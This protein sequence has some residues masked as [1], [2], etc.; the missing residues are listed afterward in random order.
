MFSTSCS[1]VTGDTTTPKVY[2]NTAIEISETA[3]TL[4]FLVQTPTKSATAQDV[5]TASA[6]MKTPGF[7]AII[8]W[9]ASLVSED[10]KSFMDEVLTK[11]GIASQIHIRRL[12]VILDTTKGSGPVLDYI[13]LDV[14][15]STT[16]FGQSPGV[17]TP[18]LFLIS[19][20]WSKRNGGAG[21]IKGSFWNGNSEY[22]N[23]ATSI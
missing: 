23:T 5:S 4:T 9:L 19:Y 18:I 6:D 15:I 8:E 3:M 22:P 17:K 13:S 10:L 7:V 12:I 11:D 16:A 1:I 21:T 14:E 2:F 20:T